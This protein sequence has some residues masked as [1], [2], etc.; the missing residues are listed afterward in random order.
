MT[1]LHPLRNVNTNFGFSVFFFVFEGQTDEQ[2]DVRT[3]RLMRRNIRR[4]HDI[5]N[6]T[7]YYIYF[8]IFDY[9]L[10]LYGL[11]REIKILMSKVG[12]GWLTWSFG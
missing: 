11:Y 12:G 1:Q 3:R 6:A 9:P 5:H 10:H 8:V 2:T 4:P 7:G